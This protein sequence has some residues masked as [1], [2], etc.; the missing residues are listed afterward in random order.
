[1]LKNYTIDTIKQYNEYCQI[2][3]GNVGTILTNLAVVHGYES[4]ELLDYCKT[5]KS[6]LHCFDGYEKSL[7]LFLQ[8]TNITRDYYQDIPEGKSWWPKEIWKKHKN[9][10]LDMGYDNAFGLFK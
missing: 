3:A 9:S 2:V 4:P 7:G 5:E 6:E 1:M 8:K 10:I